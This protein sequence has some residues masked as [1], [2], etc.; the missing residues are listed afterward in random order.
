M[1]QIGGWVFALSWS[2]ITGEQ[3]ICSILKKQRI[4]FKKLVCV[5]GW[6][7]GYCKGK[8]DF[9][10][11]LPWSLQKPE[12]WRE[13][14][15]VGVGSLV[16]CLLE[17]SGLLLKPGSSGV[18]SWQGCWSGGRAVLRCSSP[19]VENSSGTGKSS[20]V[21]STASSYLQRHGRYRWGSG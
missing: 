4:F 20:V 19:V 9:M 15:L 7:I 18:R 3:H 13:Q 2:G 1:Q 21:V 5:W 6:Y 16:Q 14:G 11:L 17:V 12:C 8:S 10:K